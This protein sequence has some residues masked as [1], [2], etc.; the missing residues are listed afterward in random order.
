MRKKEGVSERVSDQEG[1]RE[2][3]RLRERME[4]DLPSQTFL[5][6]AFCNV[7]QFGDHVIALH[8][9]DTPTGLCFLHFSLSP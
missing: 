2:R 6:W 3:E 4:L 1:E 5:T 8:N 7:V 9:I